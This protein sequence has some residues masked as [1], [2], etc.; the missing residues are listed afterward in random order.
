M[1]FQIFGKG[2]ICQVYYI[3]ASGFS[4]ILSE[5]KDSGIKS[6]IDQHSD[7]CFDIS[8]GFFFENSAISLISSDGE[9][10]L[11]SEDSWANTLPVSHPFNASEDYEDLLYIDGPTFP[12]PEE[13]QVCLVTYSEFENGSSRTALTL[14]ENS[15]PE[16]F[17]INCFNVDCGGF[18]GKTTY[19]ETIV[20]SEEYDFAESA[21]MSLC[22]NGQKIVISPPT[23]ENP[24]S[25]QW[26]YVFDPQQGEHVL[27]FL[28]S[29]KFIWFDD[30]SPYKLFV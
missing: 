6:L 11:D 5:S 19:E 24:R 2:I 20:G 15:L 9:V 16:D 28:G 21:I 27:D 26:L 3:S 18:V 8:K 17:K 10:I 23:F 14:P 12:E 29:K 22:V 13:N 4:R 1:V 25:R 7:Y 30:S